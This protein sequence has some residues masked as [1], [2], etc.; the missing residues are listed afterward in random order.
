MYHLSSTIK[1]RLPHSCKINPEMIF[2]SHFHFYEAHKFAQTTTSLHNL[3]Y[4]WNPFNVVILWLNEKLL[5]KNIYSN[6]HT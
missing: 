2:L 3:K 4:E 5:R 6:E 1:K